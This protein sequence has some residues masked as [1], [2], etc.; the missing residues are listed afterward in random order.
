MQEIIVGIYPLQFSN[1]PYSNLLGQ[2]VSPFFGKD[3]RN[4]SQY[5]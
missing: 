4:Y 3:G 1:V 2:F 5:V